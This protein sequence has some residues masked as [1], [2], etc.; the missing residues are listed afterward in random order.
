M[1][2][3]VVEV[4]AK[5]GEGNVPGEPGIEM[6]EVEAPS[7]MAAEGIVERDGYEFVR[8]RV[9]GDPKKWDRR[10]SWIGLGGGIVIT[11]LLLVFAALILL[12][13]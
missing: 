2:K 7:A 4:K 12:Y 8:L 5:D 3:Y 11:V 6:L 1:P 10:E 9:V 13:L